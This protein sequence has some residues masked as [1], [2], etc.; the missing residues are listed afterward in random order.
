M[1]VSTARRSFLRGGKPLA[2]DHQ[3]PWTG[4]DFTEQCLRCGDCIAA[5]PEQVLVKG[6]GGFPQVDFT[7]E[8]CTLCQG[9][10]E[11]CPAPVFDVQHPAFSWRAE[12][13]SGCLAFNNIHCQSCQEHCEAQ[14]IKFVYQLGQMPRPEVNSPAC[15]GCGACLAAC[16][17]DAIQ[18]REPNE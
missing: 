16:P 8:G 11:V 12:I 5:C 18:L 13:G 7:H 17:Q 10:V 9:C 15:T 1:R 4:S 6:D 3:P 2:V 14:A